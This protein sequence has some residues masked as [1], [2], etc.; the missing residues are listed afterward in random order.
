MF[1]AEENAA[2]IDVQDSI[3]IFLLEVQNVRHQIADASI[4]DHDVEPTVGIDSLFHRGRDLFF[5]R[6]I[7]NVRCR[8]ATGCADFASDLIHFRRATDVL[9]SKLRALF[10]ANIGDHDFHAFSGETLR[11][12]LAET[13]MAT[14]AG[15]KSNLAIK[16]I[17]YSSPCR[18]ITTAIV[19]R[20]SRCIVL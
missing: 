12:C 16:C 8:G 11:H 13:A 14:R 9:G 6:N 15:D 17:H 18:S 19:R 3:P 2:Q 4:V 20:S 7:A 1:D 10:D 5:L